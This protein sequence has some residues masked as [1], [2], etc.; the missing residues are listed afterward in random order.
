MNT[1]TL[2]KICVAFNCTFDEIM[3]VINT[4]EDDMRAE[5]EDR[6]LPKIYLKNSKECFMDSIRNKLIYVTPEETVRQKVVSYLIEELKVPRELIT[7]EDRLSHYGVNSKRRVDILISQYDAE[8]DSRYPLTVVECKAPDV[9]V[10][11]S[12]VNQGLD[13]A[14]ALNAKYIMITNGFEMNCFYWPLE[15]EPEHIEALPDYPNMIDGKYVPLP[16]QE[17]LVRIPF[18]DLL[19]KGEE[20]YVDDIFGVKTPRSMIPCMT[21]LAECFIDL[22]H[23]FPIGNYGMFS[24]L[25]DYGIRYLSYGTSGGWTYNSVYRSILIQVDDVT[26]FISFGF[27]IYSDDK[28]ILAVAIDDPDMTPHHALQLTVDNSLSVIGNRCLFTHSGRIAVGHLGSG[29][30]SELKAM[31]ENAA[32]ELMQN[33]K[34]ILGE[35]SNDCLWYMDTEQ[36]VTF[37]TNLIK[38]ALIRDKYRKLLKEKA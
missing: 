7:L 23:R 12:A 14:E 31:I 25:E 32:P 5:F 13:Y 15:G 3:E 34:I 27:N 36:V 20:W 4:E 2:A 10:G 17:P 33:G 30:I 35:M 1:G 24:V 16:E 38:Y 37:L 9:I 29:R 11:A 8:T 22:E 6:K 26:E 28:T 19:Q 18:E 21:N